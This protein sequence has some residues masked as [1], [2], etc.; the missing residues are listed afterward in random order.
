MA[1]PEPLCSDGPND[2]LRKI[3]LGLVDIEAGLGSS[4]E[5]DDEG[6]PLTLAAESINFVGAGVTA[7]AVGNDVTVTIPADVV[8][9][10][11]AVNDNLAAFDGVT[12][13]LIK[14]SGIAISSIVTNATLQAGSDAIGS[15]VDS[16]AVVFPTAFAAAPTVVA[17]ISKL[18]V[19]NLIEV[20][21]VTSTVTTL[22]FTAHLSA[23]TPT[24]N[25][26]INWMAK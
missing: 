19:E 3:L 14:D 6:V 11:G 16:I 5:V 1:I 12:G 25:Y 22:G 2:L 7:T 4:L 10:A 26:R 18:T 24:A 21:I 17:T 13:K 8:G 23:T 9:P 15:G 20:N